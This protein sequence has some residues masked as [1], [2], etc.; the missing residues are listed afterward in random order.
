MAGHL[1]RDQ[2]RRD[3]LDVGA[4]PL[5][6]RSSRSPALPLS[7]SPALPRY[8]LRLCDAPDATRMRTVFTFVNSRSPAA[9]SSRP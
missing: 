5:Q 9:L 8:S 4:F 6:L 7:R 2:T 1:E 3:P